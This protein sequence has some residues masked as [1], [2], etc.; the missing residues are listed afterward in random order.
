MEKRRLGRTGLEVS[1]IGM[2]GIPIQRVGNEAAAEILRA[3]LAAGIN[4]F[5][6]ARGYTDSEEKF[7]LVLGRQ[8]PRPVIATKS[9]ARTREGM[10]ADIERSLAELKVDYIDLYQLHNVRSREELQ[11][12]LAPDG[13]LAALRTAQA[14]GKVR[15]VGITGHVVDTLV[16]AVQTGEFETIQFPFNAV[17]TE[18]AERLLPLAEKLDLGVIVM[19]PLAGGALRPAALA[20]RFLLAYPVSTIIPG[21]DSVE[22][23]QENAALGEYAVPLSAAE[24]EELKAQIARLGN[25]F[26]RRCE[27]CLPCPQGI[28]IPLVFTF[29]G[30]WTRYGLKEWAEERYRAL[31][32]KAGACVECGTCER[33]CPYSLPIRE[34]L[35]EAVNHFGE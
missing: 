27:Y 14:A 11:Q 5:D 4:F 15:H 3:A 21:V 10:T 28:R 9:M 31:D 30:Y 19:K 13:A 25:R 26:C 32:V 6:T 34:M 17:E 23:V 1:L 33:R 35:K 29:D 22:Q 7:G 2:G 8:G 16:E 20:L 12:V 24:K 18:G